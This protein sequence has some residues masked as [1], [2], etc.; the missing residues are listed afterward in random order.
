MGTVVTKLKERVTRQ[1]KPRTKKKRPRVFVKKGRMTSQYSQR[2]VRR[3]TTR[4]RTNV[5]RRSQKKPQ[6]KVATNIYTDISAPDPTVTNTKEQPVNKG[7]TQ[8]SDSQRRRKISNRR[9]KSKIVQRSQRRRTVVERRPLHDIFPKAEDTSDGGEVS[10]HK[11]QRRGTKS[12]ASQRSAKGSV[13]RKKSSRKLKKTLFP[14][15]AVF[16]HIDANAIKA[17]EEVRLSHYHVTLISV[18]DKITY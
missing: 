12:R 9:G 6:T 11:F 8:P 10:V 16:S 15:P 7:G 14:S 3:T 4:R 1:R 5:S 17:G 18:S 2:T 13:R